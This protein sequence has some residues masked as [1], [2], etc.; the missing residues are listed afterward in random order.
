MRMHGSVETSGT[1]ADRRNRR[2]WRDRGGV[3]MIDCFLKSYNTDANVVEQVF[4]EIPG[5]RN[6]IGYREKTKRE[7]EREGE[8]EGE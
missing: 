1:D 7:R 5:G 2:V 6:N 4:G 3:R 8:I